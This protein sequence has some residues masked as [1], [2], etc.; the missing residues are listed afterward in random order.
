M[1]PLTGV[2][3]K[4]GTTRL[5][6]DN[7]SVTVKFSPP[8]GERNFYERHAGLLRRAGV[9]ISDLHWSGAHLDGTHWIAVQDI[10][11]PHPR[12][13]CIDPEQIQTLFFLY[14]STW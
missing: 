1:N 5:I 14:S 3:G 2:T 8:P 4:V 13:R 12:E 7:R 9:G 10:P 6:L 11:K